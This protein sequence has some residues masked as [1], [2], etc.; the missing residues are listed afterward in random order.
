MNCNLILNYT[1]SILLVILIILCY[2]VYT[3]VLKCNSEH[4]SLN[5]DNFVIEDKANKNTIMSINNISKYIVTKS[6]AQPNK[7]MKMLRV[8]QDSKITLN[9]GHYNKTDVTLGFYF[10]KF[11]GAEDI[12]FI[13]MLVCQDNHGK[14][15]FKLSYNINNKLQ[16]EIGSHNIETPIN[17]LD[18]YNYAVIQINNKSQP[19]VSLNINNVI[20]KVKLLNSVELSMHTFIFQNFHGYI[21]KIML[22]NKLLDKSQLCKNYNCNISCFIPDGSNDYDRDVNKCIKACNNKCDDIEKCQKICVNCEIEE[23]NWDL[24]TKLIKCPWLKDIKK[25]DKSVPE[26]PK[27][28]TYPGDGKILVEWKRPYDNRMPITNYIILVYE[29][30][31]KE[32]GLKVTVSNDPKCNICEHEIGNL[33]NQV[34]YDISVRAVNGMGIGEVSN[35]E[36]VSPNGKNKHDIVK[37]IFMEL[38]DDLD[39]LITTEDLDYACD[40]KGY[41]TTENMILDKLDNEDI[42]I[43]MLVKNIQ[44]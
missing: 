13:N 37:N 19:E 2:L 32:N 23:E 21:G 25:L 22:H 33:K 8:Y 34:Y 36:T 11:K 42:D 39:N 12:N 40:N 24:E 5:S 28:R 10:K 38:D 1:N 43:E 15:V 4:F 3:Y 41:D 35:I 17:S 27:I 26:A 16:F 9:R 31:N 18:E 14:D 20:S 7:N 6:P 44:K 29:S 30:F